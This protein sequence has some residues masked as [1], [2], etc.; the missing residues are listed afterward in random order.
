MGWSASATAR[1]SPPRLSGSGI[2]PTSRS[3]RGW[4]RSA[5]P[6]PTSV[7]VFHG[8]GTASINS[9]STPGR[10]LAGPCSSLEQVCYCSDR[11]PEGVR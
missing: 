10:I 6:A 3:E 9:H 5:P 11:G 7:F 8:L 1:T 2:G 4:T